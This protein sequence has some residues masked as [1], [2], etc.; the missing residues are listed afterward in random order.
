MVFYYI[1]PAIG[2]LYFVLTPIVIIL[3]LD[4]ILKTPVP[5]EIPLLVFASGFLNYGATWLI[6][7]IKSHQLLK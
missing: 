6:S 4:M 2:R 1:S 7:F 5:I 3:Y